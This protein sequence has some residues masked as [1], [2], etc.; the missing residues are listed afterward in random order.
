MIER[1]M[2]NVQLEEPGRSI[3]KRYDE[4]Q[5]RREEKRDKDPSGLTS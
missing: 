3:N 4:K 5:K 1:C 2:Y